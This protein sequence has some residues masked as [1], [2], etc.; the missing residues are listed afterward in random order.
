M[1]LLHLP[2]LVAV[3]GEMACL[4]ALSPTATWTTF[5]Q[6]SKAVRLYVFFLRSASTSSG[7]FSDAAS[8]VATSMLNSKLSLGIT[9][10]AFVRVY[11]GRAKPRTSLSMVLDFMSA[12]S[13]TPTRLASR[14]LKSLTSPRPAGNL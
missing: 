6:R 8:F 1:R 7:T 14:R 4:P 10:Q 3:R 2:R 11:C 12:M 5:F 9:L 13:V